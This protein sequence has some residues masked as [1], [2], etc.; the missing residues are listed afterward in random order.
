MANTADD[1]LYNDDLDVSLPG[2]GRLDTDSQTLDG[3]DLLDDMLTAP[4]SATLRTDTPTNDDELLGPI[5]HDT[6][7]TI[8]EG[9]SSHVMTFPNQF[10][11]FSFLHPYPI[12]E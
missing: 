7:D 3:E 8:I 4:S 6:T 11:C 1:W 5:S 10:V 2:R 12:H 9:L